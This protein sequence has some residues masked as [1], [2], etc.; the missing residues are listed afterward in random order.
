MKGKHHIVIETERLKYEFDIR[1]NITVIQGDSATGKTT[2]VEILAEFSRNRGGVRVISDVSCMVFSGDERHWK[3]FF[4]ETTENI[5]FIDEDY[6][7]VF[8]VDFAE[9]IRKSD[10]YYVIISRRPLYNIP[11]SVQE[12]YGIRTSGKYHFPE[13]VYQEFYPIYE[14]EYKDTEGPNLLVLVEDSKAG[15]QFFS[16]IIKKGQC[17]GCG[18][19]SKIYAKMMENDSRQMLIIAD[20]AAFGAYIANMVSFRNLKKKVAIYL[21]ESFE[22]LILKSGVLEDRSVEE[23][24]KHPEDYIDSAEYFSWERFFT[25]LLREKSSKDRYKQYNKD[26]LPVFYKEGKNADSIIRVLPEEIRSLI[27]L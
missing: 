4:E 1:R 17:I 6:E 7:F 13:K 15:Y 19:N 21:P 18:G 25:E 2:L 16:E 20:G 8:G 10:N 12:I 26:L 22:W 23:I 14:N 24:L 5:I 11:Y 9:Y 3:T 27:G